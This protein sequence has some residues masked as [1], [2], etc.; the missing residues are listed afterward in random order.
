MFT[1]SK[2]SKNKRPVV[3]ISQVGDRIGV[4]LLS[5]FLKATKE[6]WKQYRG[7][8]GKPYPDW[9][10]RAK[11]GHLIEIPEDKVFVFQG[12]SFNTN[13]SHDKNSFNAI[14]KRCMAQRAVFNTPFVHDQSVGHRARRYLFGD[15]V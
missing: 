5:D 14:V 1:I 6:Y 10:M 13:D 2:K 4:V 7:G 9:N 8:N 12:K 15:S 3:C 11:A